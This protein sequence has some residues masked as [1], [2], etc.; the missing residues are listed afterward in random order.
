MVRNNA[1]QF[2]PPRY[3]WNFDVLSKLIELRFAH[4]EV[5]LRKYIRNIDVII[6]VDCFTQEEAEVRN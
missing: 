3:I 2:G 6:D 4:E 5:Q 1:P